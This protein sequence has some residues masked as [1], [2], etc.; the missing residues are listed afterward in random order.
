MDQ[1]TNI[2]SQLKQL[3]VAGNKS[4]AKVRA[5]F[6]AAKAK[7]EVE[8][9]KKVEDKKQTS[10]ANAR[11]SLSTNP[12][13]KTFEEFTIAYN[14]PTPTKP[15]T[16]KQETK[17]QPKRKSVE[18]LPTPEPKEYKLYREYDSKGIFFKS[19]L[20]SIMKRD[21]NGNV[22]INVG[23]DVT[24]STSFAGEDVVIVETIKAPKSGHRAISLNVNRSE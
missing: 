2:I 23:E 20:K 18:S 14:E 6:A 17:K 3:P 7:A 9:I 21:T 4:V 15:T 22:I 13:D 16:T 12:Y 24:Q 1:Y 10:L 5:L 11:D 8:A 19:N